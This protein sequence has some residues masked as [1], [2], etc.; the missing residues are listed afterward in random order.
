MEKSSETKRKR[1]RTLKNNKDIGEKNNAPF[2]SRLRK[3]LDNENI[4]NKDFA[5]YMDVSTQMIS[6]W[7]T[8]GYTP[9]V[10]KII[11]IAERFKVSTDYL[12]GMTDS[13][14]IEPQQIS[15][16]KYIGLSPEAT[17]HLADIQ[18]CDFNT[19]Y[20]R[21]DI[22]NMII[23]SGHFRSLL[24]SLCEACA[25]SASENFSD[26]TKTRQG[27]DGSFELQQ[28]SKA[29][30]IELYS[31]K[32]SKQFNKIIEKILKEVSDNAQHNPPK[33]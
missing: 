18:Y 2:A 22:L 10:E 28:L 13:P 1:G 5:S 8:G 7:R 24:N 3:L 25:I 11:K 4:S 9:D 20:K 23:L 15:A 6:Y 26:T 31:Q 17:E 33:E 32:A 29:D 19:P 12:L 27:H 14:T 16:E 30:L 21:T